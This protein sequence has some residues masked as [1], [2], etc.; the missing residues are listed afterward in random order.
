MQEG[1]A[2]AGLRVIEWAQFMAGP[3]CA[4]LLADLGAQVIK[5][6]EPFI[7]DR[8]R[9]EGP[10]PGDIPHPEKSGLF[11]YLNTNKLGITLNLKNP[12]GAK[13]FQELIRAADFLVEDFPPGILQEMSLG[14]ED[15]K[16]I[17]PRLIMISIT[18]FGQ[19]GPNKDYKAHDINIMAAGGMA[20]VSGD[21]E[22]EPVIFAGAQSEYQAGL[23]ALV[24]GLCAL[25]YREFTGLGQQV[26]ISKQEAII[27]IL[28]HA[29]PTY[30]F[31]GQIRKRSGNRHPATHPSSNYPCKDG[32]VMIN[33]ATD[34][35]WKAF[36]EW[37][38]NP[39]WTL[40]PKMD[41]RQYRVEHADE[42]DEKV[43]QWLSQKTKK[44]IYYGGQER[45]LPFTPLFDIK[46]VVESAQFN[47]R[48]F[49]V[50]TEHPEAGKVKMPGSPCKLSETPSKIYRPAPR[51]GEH[52]EEIY[53][54]SL[55]YLREDLIK[56]RGAGII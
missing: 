12:H 7:G 20:Y 31:Q 14:Y 19:T 27:A 9:R 54:G 36:V 29:I 41:D 44:E 53:C 49:F 42:I 16:E 1:A 10:F 13:I 43:I 39:A 15:L 45:H 38:G 28:E 5:V 32:Y 52:N 46:E 18:P 6:E 22:R 4:R 30:S 23:N 33:P 50:E 40:D 2:L 51:L 3:F 25:Y 11:L 47:A 35:Q 34:L 48:E 56:L 8:S 21:P 26:D 17:N 37:M 55:G 24:G